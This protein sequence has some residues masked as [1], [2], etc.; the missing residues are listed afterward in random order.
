MKYKRNVN[1]IEKVAQFGF[2][3]QKE[4]NLK[5]L[6]KGNLLILT[7]NKRSYR[8]LKY[9]KSILCFR[10]DG[11][12]IETS[13]KAVSVKAVLTSFASCLMVSPYFS[14]AY[15]Y[16]CFW[17]CTRRTD[18]CT[19]QTNCRAWQDACCH[20]SSWRTHSPKGSQLSAKGNRVWF[21]RDIL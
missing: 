3:K 8:L 20:P 2:T 10:D 7:I 4:S 11:L 1:I 14:A 19:V 9:G 12:R 18:R 13:L 15:R 16:A 17:N 21:C 5:L 6:R